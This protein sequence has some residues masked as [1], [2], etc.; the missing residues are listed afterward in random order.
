MYSHTKR[1]TCIVNSQMAR[2]KHR[3][4]WGVQ[5]ARIVLCLA[6]ILVA[7]IPVPLA[8]D[9]GPAK[10]DPRAKRLLA[11]LY[12]R[13]NLPRRHSSWKPKRGPW[14]PFLNQSY[15]TALPAQEQELYA[16]AMRLGDCQTVSSLLAVG[17]ILKHPYLQVVHGR[18]NVGRIFAS[19]VIPATIDYWFCLSNLSLNRALREIAKGGL[20]IERPFPVDEFTMSIMS[21][22]SSETRQARVLATLC[23]TFGN[24]AT[25]AVHD[26]FLPA[27]KLLMT[28]VNGQPLARLPP[29]TEYY[30]LTRM[31]VLQMAPP[32]SRARR[33]EL[34]YKLKT[35]RRIRIERYARTRKFGRAPNTYWDCPPIGLLHTWK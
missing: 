29:A 28:P 22:V 18:Q 24:L 20:A 10:M 21:G 32:N 16:T 6:V 19:T 31:D 30:L 7:G 26:D 8:G 15:H 13:R 23:R 5:V 12:A 4:R 11:E 14:R 33:Q 1:Q 17:F 35:R 27:I 34:A 9:T 3:T 25:L 2:S